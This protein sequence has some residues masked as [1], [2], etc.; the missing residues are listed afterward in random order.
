MPCTRSVGLAVLCVTL[1]GGGLAA[2]S[3]QLAAGQP[4][5][6]HDATAS[7]DS[8]QAHP[9]TVPYESDRSVAYHVLAAPAYAL[10]GLTRPIG[11]TITYLERNYP[12]LFKP[13][14]RRRG[15]LPLAELGGPVGVIGGLA[16]YDNHLFGTNQ[17]AR[18]EG[19]IGARDFFEVEMNYAVP[20]PAG[21]STYFA[22]EG[23]YFRE[24]RARF[25]VDGID[26]EADADETRFAREQLDATARLQYA[27][28]RSPV[29]GGLSLRYERIDAQPGGDLD[30]PAS[31]RLLDAPGLTTVD[32]LTPRID[33]AF[34]LTR[35]GSP[36]IVAGTQLFLEVGYAHDLR[37]KR[38]RY[39][40]YAA[41]IQQYVPVPFLPAG[42]RLVVRT[43]L[44][45]VEPLFGGE[46]VPFYQ[47]PQLGGQ[48]SLRG[49]LSQRFRDDGAL[50][51]TAE[52]RYPV[53]TNRYPTWFGIDA[54][55]F[56][57]TGQVFD[58]FEAVTPRHFKTTVGGG[59]H[60]LNRRGLSARFEVA[61]SVE[62]T[63]L[64]LTVRPS[65][66]RPPR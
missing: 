51:L 38:F 15:V 37:G 17:Q 56:V 2:P 28:S 64:I 24:P 50:L 11:W 53:W 47:L 27:P 14:P 33:V 58:T 22:F 36:R 32:L 8:T 31:A 39:G 45:Q 4:A 44:E 59:L 62:G 21:P 66:Q 60:M 18:L 16:L 48:R 10:R 49:Y 52:Y 61:Y 13:T 42:R 30:D 12:G 19:V 20:Q 46:A 40:R 65:L 26:S 7:V 63:Q 34:D 57:D 35:S 43:R 6:D 29:G 3:L 5:P 9:N 54:V 25:F 41:A 1:I 55:F 23:N